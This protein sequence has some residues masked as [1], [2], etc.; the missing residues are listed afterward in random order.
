MLCEDKTMERELEA[1]PVHPPSFWDQC[2][3]HPAQKTVQF[4]PNPD[5]SSTAGWMIL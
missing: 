1:S 4:V 3:S 2:S 5:A